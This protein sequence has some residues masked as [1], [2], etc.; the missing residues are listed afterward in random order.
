VKLK[1]LILV[2]ALQ[3]AWLL[4]TVATQETALALGKVILLETRPVDPRDLLRGDYLV[5]SYKISDAPRALFEPPLTE[6]LPYGETVWIAVAPRGEFHEFVRASRQRFEPT[7]DEV[8][9]RSEAVWSGRRTDV[10]TLQYGL[11]RYLRLEFAGGLRIRVSP[12]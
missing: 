1:L 3:T 6:N 8:L 11:E 2:L 5:L 10:Q 9:L 7:A 4:G 12:T